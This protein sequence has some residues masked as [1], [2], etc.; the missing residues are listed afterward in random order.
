MSSHRTK[1]ALKRTRKALVRR[2]SGCVGGHENA[3]DGH[4][5]GFYRPYEQDAKVAHVLRSCSR[6]RTRCQVPVV[7]TRAEELMGM[8]Q[9][10]NLIELRLTGALDQID[11]WEKAGVQT[12]DMLCTKGSRRLFRRTRRCS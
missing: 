12:G 11:A 8:D 4:V 10:R 2:L 1:V 7:V 9:L 3:H 5:T 6:C